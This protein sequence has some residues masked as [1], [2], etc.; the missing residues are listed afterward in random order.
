M[1]ISKGLIV[2]LF[3]FTLWAPSLQAEE[4][5]PIG[6]WETTGDDGQTSTSIV[7]IFQDG[8]SLSGKIIKITKKGIKPDALCVACSGELKDKPIV[9]LRILWDMKKTGDGWGSG[10]VLD[11]DSGKIYKCSISLEGT[12]LKVRGFLGISMFGRTQVWRRAK[13][14]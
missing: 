10:F 1:Q 7:Q 8:E 3:V 2:M 11:P 6:Y 4:E 12:N 14:S 13:S 5:T 9:G